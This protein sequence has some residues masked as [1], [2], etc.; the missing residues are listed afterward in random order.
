MEVLPARHFLPV[1]GG[2]LVEVGADEVPGRGNHWVV[3]ETA[4]K[5]PSGSAPLTGVRR[6]SAREFSGRAGDS[7]KYIT[8]EGYERTEQSWV[9]PPELETGARD[10]G[11]SW[12]MVFGEDR[13]KEVGRG[14]ASPNGLRKH[15]DLRRRSS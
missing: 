6:F 15:R 11:Q 3:A 10:T 1:E 2:G 12:P 4:S 9:H 7:K 5:I 13:R 14:Q 8:P